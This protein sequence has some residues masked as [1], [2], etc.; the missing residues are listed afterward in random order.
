[1]SDRLGVRGGRA[2]VAAY[3]APG[4]IV[5]SPGNAGGHEVETTCVSTTT[6]CNAQREIV[7]ADLCPAA[8][9]NEASQLLGSC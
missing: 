4:F 7:F 8:Y 3:G 6:P 5:V 2:H 9:M 1:V